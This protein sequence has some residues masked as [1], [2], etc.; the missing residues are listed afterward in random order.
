MLKV[1]SIRGRQAAHLTRHHGRGVEDVAK[2]G[3]NKQAPAS[4]A[5]HMSLLLPSHRILDY[6]STVD[7]TKV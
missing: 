2:A 6:K 1:T 5:I 7:T 3:G 4:A